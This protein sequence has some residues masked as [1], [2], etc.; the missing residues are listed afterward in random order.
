MATMK[1][2][3]AE[4]HG[5]FVKAYAAIRIVGDSGNVYSDQDL[6]R[7]HT[8]VMLEE[9]QTG[10]MRYELTYSITLIEQ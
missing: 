10:G 5:G 7:E 4:H 8:R 3:D 6:C 9:W 1:L 2:C